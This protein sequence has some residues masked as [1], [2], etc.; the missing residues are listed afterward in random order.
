MSRNIAIILIVVAFAVGAGVGVTGFILAT[1]GNDTP[2]VD[3]ASVVPTLDINAEPTVNP[4]A[5]LS[6]ENA[7]LRAT[8]EAQSTA[9]AEPQATPEPEADTEGSSEAEN[10]T[11]AASAGPSRAL[12]RISEDDSEA[13]FYIDETLLGQDITVVGTTRRI[14]GDVIVNFDNPT[15]SQ[16]GQIA[17]NARTL[18]TDNEFRDSATRSR[19]LNTNQHEFITF[20]PT[21]FEALT[22]D[23]V[24][25]GDTVEFSV[26]G[27]L[28][29]NG[30]TRSVT[31]DVSV[32]VDSLDRISG[33]AR[34]E[35]L[36]RDFNITISAPPTVANIGETVII[37]LDFVALAVTQ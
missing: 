6:T 12:Y 14:A 18:R 10:S 26:V 34:T 36:Y 31:F 37:E 19:I 33:L 29:I 4:I 2:S 35:V 1:G 27:D 5:A 7:Q 17:V 16:L 3:T 11:A 20:V 28:T 24:N 25:V 21:A 13:R 15:A 30:T 22:T 32:T 9:L 8:I 23:A